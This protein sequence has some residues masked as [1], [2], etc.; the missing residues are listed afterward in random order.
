MADTRCVVD[1]V[2]VGPCRRAERPAAGV[3]V[4]KDGPK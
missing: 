2:L 1:V 4:K 3:A